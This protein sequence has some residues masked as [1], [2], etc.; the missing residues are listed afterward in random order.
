MFAHAWIADSRTAMRSRQSLTTA[1]AVNFSA[2]MLLAMSAAESL[3]RSPM[4]PP[5]VRLGASGRG[6][7]DLAEHRTGA[8]PR[9][10]RIVEVEDAAD[11]LAR[12]IEPADRLVVGVQ[13][14]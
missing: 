7:G 1:S 6:A 9:A 4:T 5:S 13:D 8:E 11:E 10:A 2:A 14:L 3:L 12:G